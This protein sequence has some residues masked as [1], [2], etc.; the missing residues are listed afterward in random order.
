[1]VNPVTP[2]EEIESSTNRQE[3]MNG[4]ENKSV[5]EGKWKEI[6][7]PVPWGHLAGT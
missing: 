1:M 7:V 3:E 2:S 6:K 5:L 4:T